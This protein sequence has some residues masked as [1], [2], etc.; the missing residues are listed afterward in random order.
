MALIGQ[1]LGRD[2]VAA[3]AGAERGGEIPVHARAIAG[4]Q[5]LR[6]RRDGDEYVLNGQKT[7]ITN[8]PYADTIVLYAKLDE[9]EKGL[10]AVTLLSLDQITRKLRD[11]DQGLSG[12]G[13][14][15]GDHAT[16]GHKPN[17]HAAEG[18]RKQDGP[19]AN[20]HDTGA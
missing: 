14:A 7:W 8:G 2:P 15:P 17:G 19:A 16:R 20:G 18:G 5:D 3:I 4:G 1:P 11:L 12:E 6:A 10:V 13:G 9:R